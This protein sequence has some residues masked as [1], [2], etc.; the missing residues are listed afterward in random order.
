VTYERIG[1]QFFGGQV[2]IVQLWRDGQV[3]HMEVS[4]LTDAS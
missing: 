3:Y 2:S 1:G 4:N